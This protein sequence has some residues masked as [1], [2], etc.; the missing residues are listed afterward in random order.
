LSAAEPGD[1]APFAPY[2]DQVIQP[3]TD[4]LL[5][6][7]GPDLADNRPE[8]GAS[9]SEWRTPPLWGIGYVGDVL[10]TPTDPFNPNGSPA[11]PNYL[12]DGRARSLMEA[13]LWHGG[14]G[15]A[16]RDVVL[17]MTASERDALIEY[18]K[19]PFVDP[20]EV[21]DPEACLADVT[22]SGATIAGQHGFGSPDGAIDLD[23]LGF[24][25][26]G[27]AA[28][29]PGADLTTSGAALAGQPGFGVSDAIVDFDDLGFFLGF[30]LQGC[31]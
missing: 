18:V 8:H 22:T 6:D 20:L 24:Y 26:N 30:W 1:D 10:G 9:G 2:R 5:H 28:G 17:A 15:S 12:H 14:E 4:M 25:L 19:F 23:D 31:P 3:F 16:S 27:W 7:M 13:I 21:T 11:E 29:E